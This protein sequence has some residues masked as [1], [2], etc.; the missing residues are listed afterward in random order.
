MNVT[1]KEIAEFKERMHGLSNDEDDNLIRI[2]S[3]CVGDLQEKCGDYNFED[4]SFKELVFERARYVYNDALEFFNKN[5][6]DQ[7]NQLGMRKALK[8]IASEGDADA[9]V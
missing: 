3:T 6:Q 2:L 7:I 4:D 1:S 8:E 5:F 9:T